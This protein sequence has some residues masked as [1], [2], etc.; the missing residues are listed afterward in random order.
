MSL[1]RTPPPFSEPVVSNPEPSCFV[2]GK[3]MLENQECTIITNCNHSFHRSCI[4]HFL[5]NTS[6]CPTCKLPCELSN[7]KNHNVN[8]IPKS[9][10]R[11]RPRGAMAGRPNTHSQSKNVFSDTQRSLMEFGC[12]N[13]EEH[14]RPEIETFPTTPENP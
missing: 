6:E 12:G 3:G 13:E 14:I 2:C 4:E 10:H 7:L 8:P 5:G 11:G 1:P 9:A